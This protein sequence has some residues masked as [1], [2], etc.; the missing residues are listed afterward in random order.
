MGTTIRQRQVEIRTAKGVILVNIDAA[1]APITAGNFLTYVRSGLFDQSSFYRIVAPCNQRGQAV[2]INVIQG[3]W[4]E[5]VASPRPPIPHEP[6]CE[7][8]LC[9]RDGAISMARLAP[10]TAA[11]AFFICVGDQP[12]LDYGGA[13][14]PDGQ[15]FAAFGQVI[16]GMDVVRAIW[17]CAQTEQFLDAPIPIH[18]ASLATAPEPA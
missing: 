14:N 17:G 13:R 8:G 5:D 11:A 4:R 1:A 10:G 15:G 6:T 9:H 2:P 12:E 16:K 18:A 3:G 7:T